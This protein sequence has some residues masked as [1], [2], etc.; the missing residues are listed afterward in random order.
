MRRPTWLLT[1]RTKSARRRQEA[2]ATAAAHQ[3]AEHL[4]A[5]RRLLNE[6]TRA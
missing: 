1:P 2:L 3:Q 5:L 6:A 4:A